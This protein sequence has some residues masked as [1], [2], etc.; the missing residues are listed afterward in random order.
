MPN[1]Q[2]ALPVSRLTSSPARCLLRRRFAIALNEPCPRL[3]PLLP[4]TDSRFRPDQRAL[5]LGEW[6]VA[7]QEKLRLEEKQRQARRQRK[8]AGLE[9]RPSWFRQVGS[10]EA[11]GGLTATY[12][13][14]LSIRGG[15]GSTWPLQVAVLPAMLRC[16]CWPPL[17]LPAPLAPLAVIPCI[18]SDCD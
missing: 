15:N 4:P 16:S 7:T 11:G 10:A 2:I 3:L 17:L 12:S 14:R 8:A 18:A 1:R 13:R 5:E 9:Y 6:T